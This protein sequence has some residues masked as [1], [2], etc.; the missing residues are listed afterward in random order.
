MKREHLYVDWKHPLVLLSALCLLASAVS[1][2]VF[3]M[4]YCGGWIAAIAG[5][6][7]V[8][9]LFG[10]EMLYKTSVPIWIL[11]LSVVL[12]RNTILV[13]LGCLAFCICYTLI[14]S[15]QMK[16]VWLLICQLAVLG[17]AGFVHSIP[18][19][20]A[21]ESLLLLYPAI[22]VHNDGK[23]HPVWGDRYPQYRGL[24]GFLQGTAHN[25][26]CHL[27]GGRYRKSVQRCQQ[28]AFGIDHDF[29]FQHFRHF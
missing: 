6:L 17:Y 10:D 28:A 26:P 23:Y 19:I 4:P 29:L 20:F 2:A 15:G 5:Y 27:Q 7:M 18:V 24:C 12:D 25:L 14:V 22:R 11:G 13:W 9:L 16:K 1:A 8:L 21:A 3:M